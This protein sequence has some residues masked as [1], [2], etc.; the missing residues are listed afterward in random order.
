MDELDKNQESK[1]T[2][3]NKSDY[4]QNWLEH[5]IYCN[6]DLSIDDKTSVCLTEINRKCEKSFAI[7]SSPQSNQKHLSSCPYPLSPILGGKRLGSSKIQKLKNTNKKIKI[8]KKLNL[9]NDDK[10][11]CKNL[12]KQSERS[13]IPTKFEPCCMLFLL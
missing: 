4:I 10:T 12:M 3:K 7:P 5:S 2:P 1:S 11:D 6:S 13:K 9:T 8:T